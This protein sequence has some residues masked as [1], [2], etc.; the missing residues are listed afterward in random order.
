MAVDFTTI[1]NK[2][3]DSVERPKPLPAGTY[4]FVVVRH[5]FGLSAK[6][7]TPQVE[8]A[9]RPMAP[10]ADVDAALLPPGWQSRE[11]GVTF[12]L[13]DAAL[14]RLREFL[15]QLGLRTQGRPFSEVIP[16]TTNSQFLGTVT[17]DVSQ[18]NNKDVFANISSTAPAI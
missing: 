1:L 12:Y 4:T 6:K 18:R 9:C 5:E 16:E 7:Q 8:F 2:Q 3:V 17:H 11:T 13:T 10:G 15:E 14:F